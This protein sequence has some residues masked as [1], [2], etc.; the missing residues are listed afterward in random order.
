MRTKRFRGFLSVVLILSMVMTLLLGSTAMAAAKSKK[1]SK[2]ATKIPVLTYHR[3]YADG[4][5]KDSGE[6]ADRYVITVSKF[7]QQMSWLKQKGYRTI[8][9]DEF[10]RWKRGKLRLPTRSVLITID[11]GHAKSIENMAT[12]LKKYGFKGTAFVI[13]KTTLNKNGSYY[14]TYDRIREMKKS[15]PQIEFQSHTY[16]LHRPDAYKKVSKK[17]FMQDAAQMKALYGFKYIAYPNG[18]QSSKM[19]KAYKKSGIR[20]GFLFGKGKN[21]YA[22]RKQNIYKLK[23]IEVSNTMSM[24]RFKKWCK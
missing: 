3:I 19:I 16:N 22:T 8:T 17:G 18:R 12:V 6:I 7:D 21:G 2:N 15:C 23:R 1:R 14:I 4:A 9:C 24:A 5:R 10:Y 20:M 11:D 13:G